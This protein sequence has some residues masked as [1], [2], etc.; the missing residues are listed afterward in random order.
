[1]KANNRI[2]SLDVF[3]GITIFA[4]LIVNNPGSWGH[5]YPV[6]K[7]AKWHGFMGADWIFPFFIFIIGFAIPIS[8][9]HQ[10][11]KGKSLFVVLGRILKRSIFLFLLGIFL[12]A[13][14]DFNWG[15]VRIPGVLQR[16]AL[17]YLFS[18]VLFLFLKQKWILVLSGFFL[19]IHWIVLTKIP[20]PSIGEPS[21]EMGKNL[22]GWIDSFVMPNHLWVHS[23]TW[24]P[25]GILGTLS[26]ISSCLFGVYY[27]QIFLVEKKFTDY[28]FYFGIFLGL[29]LV[30]LGFAWGITFPINKSLWTGSFVL[31]NSGLAIISFLTLY[32]LLDTKE[33]ENCHTS[34]SQDLKYLTYRGVFYKCFEIMGVNALAIFFLSSLF[35]KILNIPF[36][37]AANGKQIG[38]KTYLY[39]QYFIAYFSLHNASFV[40][41]LVY[42]LFWLS[43][44][45]F[46]EK[47][48]YFRM[49]LRRI[50][51]IRQSISRISDKG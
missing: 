12:N 39:N 15:N 32:V 8:I 38:L 33:R 27:G 13:F 23:K 19:F 14:P 42:T 5:I 36:L 37:L 4:M 21:L 17:V 25:E 24:D 44:F 2:L 22:A 29:L 9:S 16:I 40:W 45:T 6:F 34:V 10:R 48:S 3:R 11:S 51:N 18:A 50:F 47:G 41:A 28:Q 31:F 26:A 1:M 49:S 20:V 30:S 46:Y 7:H 35:S 43:I